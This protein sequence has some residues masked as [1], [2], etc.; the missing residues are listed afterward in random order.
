MQ[1]TVDFLER[2]TMIQLAR[3]PRVVKLAKDLG[4]NWRGDCVAAIR[5]HAASQVEAVRCGSPIPIDDLDTLRLMVADKFHVRVEFIRED[6]DIERISMECSGF[7][8]LLRQRL[9]FEFIQG[10]TEGIT[11]EREEPDSR[12]FQYLAV[13]DARGERAARAYFTAWHE[14]AH[15]LVHPSQLTFPGFRRTPALTERDKDPIESVVDHVAGRLAFYPPFFRPAL[16]RAIADRGGLTFEALEA[17]RADAAPTAS[18]FATAM[19]SIL[20]VGTPALFV[21]ADMGLKAEERRFTRGPQQA[22]DF[23]VA[24]VQ[25]KLRATTVAPSDL[26]ADSGLAIRRN[27]RVPANSVLARAYESTVDVTLGAD[28]NQDWWTTS[29]DGQLEPL[30][31]RVEAVR[32]GRYV[33]GLITTLIGL[34]QAA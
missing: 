30:P 12:F 11:L 16:D 20:L 13:V 3:E 4:L 23:A 15:L 25:E 1:P 32:R 18:L 17:A 5:E 24:T 26:V 19:G 28:E 29:R 34:R 9:D 14:L 2:T 6:D 31:I 33:Y 7:H 10:S 22:F 21:T 8:S 27:M